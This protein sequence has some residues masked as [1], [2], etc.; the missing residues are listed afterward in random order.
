MATHRFAWLLLSCLPLVPLACG[1]DDDDDPPVSGDAGEAGAAGDSVGA[2]GGTPG[3]SG[4]GGAP[5]TAGGSGGDTNPNG[6]TPS[7]GAAG[8]PGQGGAAAGSGGMG[9]ELG[10][11]GGLGGLGGYAGLGGQGG[12]DY[13]SGG[14]S[15]DCTTEVVVRDPPPALPSWCPGVIEDYNIIEGT[16]ESD[17]YCDSVLT[18]GDDFVLGRGGPDVIEASD[19]D[20]CVLG[21]RW[22]DRIEHGTASDGVDV[23]HGG[24][25]GDWFALY[26]M[27]G[28]MVLVD[29]TTAS[30]VIVFDKVSFGLTGIVGASVP[31]ANRA[32]AAGN[33]DDMTNGG[34][35]AN[36]TPC[37]IYD[38]SDGE[39]F[40][41]ADG[42]GAGLA[43]R[44]AVISTFA[45]YVLDWQDFLLE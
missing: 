17:H 21:G 7:S 12:D 15:S 32:A 33:L 28:H 5:E 16:L 27:S 42:S 23:F 26:G 37:I 24:P 6:G 45:T 18:A 38:A 20:D 22:P 2:S 39:L 1:S 8:E 3:S 19:G 4:A 10:G 13:G 9:G 25:Q 29:F 14:V 44:V 40:F 35:C 11:D 43:D 31:A 34:L 41:D 36:G 30:D